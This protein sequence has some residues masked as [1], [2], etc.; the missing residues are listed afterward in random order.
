MLLSAVS[1]LVVAQ[2]SSEVP[3][4]LTNNPVYIY[5]YIY[6]YIYYTLC[7][8]TLTQGRWRNLRF[9]EWLYGEVFI[10]ELLIPCVLINVFP[11]TEVAKCT[12]YIHNSITFYLSSIFR[13]YCAIFRE[14][15]QVLKLAIL[16]VHFLSLAVFEPRIVHPVANHSSSFLK[17][18]FGIIVGWVARYGWSPFF[19][20]VTILRRV[21]RW[22]SD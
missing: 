17:I 16:E 8:I 11:F 7:I 22:R 1:V 3:E 15:L 6:I 21:A 12:Y 9:L 18:N 13:H 4:G 19:A 5:I 20:K 2:S 14:L 10:L